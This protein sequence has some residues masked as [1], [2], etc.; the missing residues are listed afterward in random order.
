MSSVEVY[1]EE[2]KNDFAVESY[3]TGISLR[4]LFGQV[5]AAYVRG[6]AGALFVGGGMLPTMR[7]IPNEER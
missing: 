5:Y 1:S 6:A 4:K 3:M 2:D 7:I